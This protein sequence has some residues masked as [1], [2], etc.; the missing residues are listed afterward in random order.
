MI[1]SP[2]T[3]MRRCASKAHVPHE[4]F[5]D[6]TLCLRHDRF[7][8]KLPEAGCYSRGIALR[9][10]CP[11]PE[12]RRALPGPAQHFQKC[13][14]A[15]HLVLCTSKML[16]WGATWHALAL[17]LG[18]PARLLG[19]VA[20][21]PEGYIHRELPTQCQKLQCPTERACMLRKTLIQ[22]FGLAL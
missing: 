19:P 2:W 6:C 16:S 21:W 8:S 1:A 10:A 15:L 22:Q 9:G 5:R 3:T 4:T 14:S 7:E 20:P 12:V 17:N 13:S 18:S 11:A